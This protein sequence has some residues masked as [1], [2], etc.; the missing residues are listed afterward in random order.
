M[1]LSAV[2]VGASAAV[3]IESGQMAKN[4]PRCN[5]MFGGGKLLVAFNVRLDSKPTVK[6]RARSFNQYPGILHP[7]GNNSDLIFSYSPHI[8]ELKTIGSSTERILLA[9]TEQSKP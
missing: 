5:F 1:P 6:Y 3:T 4:K 9:F 2:A 8:G 7:Y